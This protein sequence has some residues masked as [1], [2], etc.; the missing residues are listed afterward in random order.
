MMRSLALTLMVWPLLRLRFSV[1]GDSAS[2]HPALIVLYRYL[3]RKI[4]PQLASR[5]ASGL[6]QKSERTGILNAV[7]SE[8]IAL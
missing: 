4:Y 1:F 7:L 3:A 5:R 6:N 8:K 2:T